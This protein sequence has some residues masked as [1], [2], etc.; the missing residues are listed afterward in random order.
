M[1]EQI[2]VS[3]YTMGD[4]RENDYDINKILQTANARKIRERIIKERCVCTFE[5]ANQASIVYKPKNLIKA[6]QIKASRYL[7]ESK[8]FN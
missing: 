4:L 7:N 2:G 5:C 6:L 1:L 3:P 8:L